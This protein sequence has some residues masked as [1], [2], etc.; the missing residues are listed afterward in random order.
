MLILLFLTVFVCRAQAVLVSTFDNC[1]SPEASNSMTRLQF[2]PIL[3]SASFGDPGETLT[4]SVWGT[5][6]GANGSTPSGR[7]RVKRGLGADGYWDPEWQGENGIDW[8]E[9]SGLR[10]RQLIQGTN[11]TTSTEAPATYFGGSYRADYRFPSDNKE[12]NYTG[13]ILDQDSSWDSVATTL[14]TTVVVSSF[15]VHKDSAYFCYNPTRNLAGAQSVN[16]SCPM[17]NLISAGNQ[18]SDNRTQMMEYRVVPEAQRTDIEYLVDEL[19]SFTV[20]RALGSSFQFAALGVTLKILAGDSA[21]TEVGCI[22]VEIA[23]ELNKSNSN[24]L[25][26]LSASVLMI[27]GLASILAAMFNPWNGTTDLF[28]FSSNYGMDDDMLRLVTPGFAD[29]LQW[30]QFMVLTGSLSLSYPVFY[31]PI[32]SN[33]AW[34]VL[35]LNTS[36]YSHEKVGAPAWRADGVYAFQAWAHGYERLAQAVGLLTTND[37]W[38][39]VMAYFAVVLIGSVIIFQLWF[40]GR[41][42]LWKLTGV[43]EEDL[44]RKNWPFTAGWYSLGAVVLC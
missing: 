4:L 44:T 42:A 5:V 33:G 11:D 26:W 13:F 20:T 6:T 28:R 15:L 38:V 12:W 10:R 7:R 29:C 36:L 19:P 40:W 9:D 16:A 39:C 17:G 21:A 22:H 24:M 35:L 31:Q 3:V 23:T 14:T 1:L 41:W 43:E 25:T 2:H 27:V 18:T 8:A 34:S 30:L 37:I 32:I